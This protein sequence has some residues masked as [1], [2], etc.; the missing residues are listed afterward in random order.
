M[1]SSEKKIGRPDLA[2][3]PRSSTRWR[4][5]PRSAALL[6]LLVRVLDHARSRRRPWRR[7]AMAM[8][9]RLMMLDGDAQQVHRDE[10][11]QHRERQASAIGTSALRRWKQEHEDHEADDDALLDQRVAQGLDGAVDQPRAVVGRSRSRRPAGGRPRVSAS[12]AFTRS[13][14][15]QRVLAVAH[16]DDA[17]HRLALAVELGDAAADLG[18]ERHGARRR[19][20]APA[21]RSRGSRRARSSRRSSRLFT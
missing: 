9:P 16:H 12:C 8:P 3:R 4:S 17:A 14:T 18:P 7:S 11:Q 20:G 15:S 21:C 5:A 13:I 1:I 2:A 19:R 10:R 6:E